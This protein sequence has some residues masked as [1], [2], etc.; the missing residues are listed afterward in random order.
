MRLHGTLHI[1]TYREGLLSRIAHDLRFILPSSVLNQTGDEI[2]GRFKLSQ[3]QLEGALVQGKLAPK[4]LTEKDRRK[5]LKNLHEK[6]L[7]SAK[8]PF[9]EVNGRLNDKRFEGQLGLRN[10]K[11]PISCPIQTTAQGFEGQFEIQPSHWGIAPFKAIFGA[12]QLQDRIGVALQF[13]RADTSH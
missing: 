13:T 1:F 3:I 9:A 6:I 12:I 11:A 4:L 5:I 7:Q 10:Q 2:T 8:H